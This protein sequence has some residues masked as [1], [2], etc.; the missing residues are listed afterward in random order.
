MCVAGEWRV[1]CADQV[2]HSDALQHQL[3]S[4]SFTLSLFI[5]LVTCPSNFGEISVSPASDVPVSD[6]SSCLNRFHNPHVHR[7]VTGSVDFGRPQEPLSQENEDF[8]NCSSL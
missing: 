2:L 1:V 7:W 4:C 6:G 8:N 3:R 5:H